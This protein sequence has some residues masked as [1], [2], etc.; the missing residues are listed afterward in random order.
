MKTLEEIFVEIGINDEKKILNNMII[1][2]NA[3]ES[4][5]LEFLFLSN[6][7]FYF[8]SFFHKNFK[9]RSISSLTKSKQYF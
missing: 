7:I 2:T 3:D 9:S 5:A 1:Q 6:N 8:I 4:E